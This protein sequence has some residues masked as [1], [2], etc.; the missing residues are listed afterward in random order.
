MPRLPAVCHTSTVNAVSPRFSRVCRLRR[1]RLLHG[2]TCQRSEVKQSHRRRRTPQVPCAQLVL[3]R[4]MPKMSL[5]IVR[6]DLVYST[7]RVVEGWGR[8]SAVWEKADIKMCKWMPSLERLQA[9]KPQLADALSEMLCRLWP[10]HTGTRHLW[11]LSHMRSA[12]RW[13][14]CTN[15]TRKQVRELRAGSSV[16]TR[17]QTL[18]RLP[19]FYIAGLAWNAR[20]R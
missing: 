7:K 18:K 6:S 1:G 15:S 16:Y 14:Q 3:N 10:A 19:K 8:G 2:D 13:R 4:L 5:R 20:Q 12:R 17:A 9:Y 11:T